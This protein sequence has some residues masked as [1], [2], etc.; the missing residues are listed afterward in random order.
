MTG[1]ERLKKFYSE[2]KELLQNKIIA[3]FL[4]LKENEK[5]LENVL[6]NASEE[7]LKK[8]DD[9]FKNYYSKIRILRYIS[10][11]IYFYTIDFDK[12]NNKRNQRF[13]L[14]LDAD[15]DMTTLNNQTPTSNSSEEDYLEKI[16]TFNELIEDKQLYLSYQRLTEKQQ[17]VLE[18]IYI[19][20]FTNKEIALLYGETPQN[21][22]KI[23]KRALEKIKKH[24]KGKNK[25]VN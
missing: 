13:N 5:L 22:S 8:L 7:N 17:R 18:L 6:M 1:K 10:N 16:I 3:S 14:T 21:I 15:E 23:H 11:L 20:G 24:Y 25:W 2:N 9:S 19:M 4:H 12:K